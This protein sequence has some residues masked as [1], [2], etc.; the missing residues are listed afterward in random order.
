M[1]PLVIIRKMILFFA[2]LVLFYFLRRIGKKRISQKTQH[3]LVDKS[4]IVE[5]KIVKD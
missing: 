4:N 5:G 3:S 1:I 2:P